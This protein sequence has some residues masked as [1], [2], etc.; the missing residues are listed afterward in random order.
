MIDLEQCGV[1]WLHPD[2]IPNNEAILVSDNFV[3]SEG[4]GLAVLA[5]PEKGNLFD[6]TVELDISHGSLN[7]LFLVEVY[8]GLTSIYKQGPK[9]AAGVC[10]SGYAGWDNDHILRCALWK[11][12]KV[13]IT[14]TSDPKKNTCTLLTTDT[15]NVRLVGFPRNVFLGIAMYANNT[16]QVTNVESNWTRRLPYL[17]LELLLVGKRASVRR[18]PNVDEEKDEFEE[19]VVPATL[20]QRLSEIPWDVTEVVFSFI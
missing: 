12:F 8:D 16:V 15:D 20:L 6:F 11:K 13:S 14:A 5:L 2:T 7:M 9:W 19:C 3:R 1:R 18:R 10:P 4:W 17:L